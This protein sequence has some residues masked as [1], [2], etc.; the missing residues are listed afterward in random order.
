MLSSWNTGPAIAVEGDERA[1]FVESW[2]KW[3]LLCPVR[4]AEPFGE[5]G[6]GW[7]LK[8]LTWSEIELPNYC[9]PK[10]T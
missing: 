1:N 4:Y 7:Q 8:R 9:L 6:W 2:R 10:I 3:K 5:D